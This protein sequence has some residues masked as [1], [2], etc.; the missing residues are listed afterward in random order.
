M[1]STIYDWN[2]DVCGWAS[3]KNDKLQSYEVD[4][5]FEIV[6]KY[7]NLHIV[8]H[9]EYHLNGDP[10]IGYFYALIRNDLYWSETLISKM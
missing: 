9:Y 5:Y 8:T 3:D 4:T 2:Y 1:N 7:E 6:P 10:K